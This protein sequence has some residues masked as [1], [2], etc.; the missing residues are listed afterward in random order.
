MK[1]DKIIFNMSGGGTQIGSLAAH[2]Y[3]LIEKEN[4]YPNIITGVSAGALLTLSVYLRKWESI[5]NMVTNFSKKSIFDI[6][7]KI[8]LRSIIRVLRKKPSLGTQNNLKKT[9]MEIS[10]EKDFNLFKE[11]YKKGLIKLYIGKVDMNSKEFIMVDLGL[12]TYDE[13]L[14]EVIT[15]ATIPVAVPPVIK[16]NRY[17]Y[18]GGLINHV[19]S[20][21]VRLK[22]EGQIKAVITAYSRPRK[23]PFDSNHKAVDITQPALDSYELIMFSNSK[24]DEIIEKDYCLNKKIPLV[25]MFSPKVMKNTYDA[26]PIRLKQLYYT[27]LDTHSHQNQLS[28]LKENI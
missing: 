5:E 3:N 7:P 2:A 1:K 15:S 26:D 22:Y 9:L 20:Y 10:P 28:S 16:N 18:D 11:H 14:K 17:Y 21:P 12:L 13:F 23:L 25:Q 27:V 4:I 24:K 19:C 6:E 8:N